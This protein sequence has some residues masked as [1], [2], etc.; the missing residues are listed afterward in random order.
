[1]GLRCSLLGHDYGESEIERER[2]EQG[3]EV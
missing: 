1:M 3:N 2:E